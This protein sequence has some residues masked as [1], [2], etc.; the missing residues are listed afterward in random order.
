MNPSL[1]RTGRKAIVGG[2]EHDDHQPKPYRRGPGLV[3]H[4]MEVQ[5]TKAR[6]NA[7]STTV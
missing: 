5:Y 2:T 6:W 7:D 1:N 3:A 4:A